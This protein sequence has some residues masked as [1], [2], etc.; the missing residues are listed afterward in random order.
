[1]RFAL[2]LLVA[3]AGV[4]PAPACAHIV[5]AR[6]TLAQFV[7]QSELAV[8]AK[9]ESG[10]KHWAAADGSDREDYYEIAV[11]E[12]LKGAPPGTKRLDFFPHAEGFPRYAAGDRAIVFLD[13]TGGRPE[14]AGT[15]ARFGWFS[16][17]G[18]G[19]EWVLAA[20][21]ATPI[22]ALARGYA[23]LAKEPPDAALAK[24]RALL[25]GALGSGVPRLESDALIELVRAGGGLVDDAAG[26]APFAAL[27]RSPDLRAPVRLPLVRLLDGHGGFEAEPVLLAMT[28]EAQTP[29]ERALLVQVAG[30]LRDERFTAWLASLVRGPD[31]ALRLAAVRALGQPWHASAA[32]ALA[33]VA[34]SA[35][36]ALA[37]AALQALAAIGTPDARS[38]LESAA[39]SAT[40]PQRRAWA[41]AA[42]RRMD[43]GAR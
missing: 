25:A 19:Q 9:F 24:R 7:A 31:P 38:A 6:E 15:A 12:T 29:G 11:V 35:D 17:Q 42:L 40:D 36:A 3:A 14:F 32:P 10:P 5:Y 39:A 4:A 33:P 28:R 26:V 13:R 1:M 23:S 16:V 8:I 20:A 34:T 22:L 18:P 43:L 41:E 21:E 30:S 27:A 37:R 2:A